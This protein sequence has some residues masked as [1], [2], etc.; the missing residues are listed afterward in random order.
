MSVNRHHLLNNA[1]FFFFAL[2]VFSSSFSIA[3]AQISFGISLLFFII[4]SVVTRYNPFACRLLCVYSAIGLYLVWMV[5]SALV[6]GASLL[7]LKEEWLFLIIPVGLFL[8]KQNKFRWMIVISLAVG[9]ILASAYGI[10]QHYTGANWFKDSPLVAA[11]DNTFYAVGGFHHSM[12]YGNYLAVASLFLVSLALLRNLQQLASNYWLVLSSGVLGLIGTIMSYSRTAVA[13]IPLGILVLAWLK[14]KRWVLG[15]I[16]LLI[17]AVALTFSVVDQLAL[18]YERAFNEDLTSERESSRTFIWLK[19][20]EIIKDNPVFGVGQGNFEKSYASYLDPS[21]NQTRNRPHAHNDILNFAA[22]SGIPGAI[23]FILM[24][25]VVYFRLH[26]IWHKFE[27]GSGKKLFAGAAA[28]SGVVFLITSLTEATFAD[29]EVRQLLMVIW[30]AG[31]WP[32]FSISGD[33]ERFKS[34]SA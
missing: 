17:V 15:S 12:T 11:E 16:A 5:I 25:G 21:K 14:G 20:I 7:N 28:V 27:P 33:G 24:W 1:V 31:L 8:F 13:A 6:N 23:F 10:I 9:V 26:Q 32:F 18:K 34:E 4:L 22:V 3:L 19:S 29:E 30:A 2:F